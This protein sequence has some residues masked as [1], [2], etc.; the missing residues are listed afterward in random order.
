[1]S[2]YRYF[3]DELEMELVE[4]TKLF[5]AKLYVCTVRWKAMIKRKEG[6]ELAAAALFQKA[7]RILAAIKRK[8]P[9]LS[10]GGVERH[11]RL[12]GL[13][14]SGA[15]NLAPASARVA[16]KFV[17]DATESGLTPRPAGFYL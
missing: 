13:S 6:D 15:I 2:A 8:L 4:G 7:H 3:C 10:S 5:N 12:C 16:M 17:S 9:I 11:A 1:M 14:S